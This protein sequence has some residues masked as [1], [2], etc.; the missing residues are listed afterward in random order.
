LAEAIGDAAA[1]ASGA[2]RLGD[3]ATDRRTAPPSTAEG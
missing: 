3:V 2:S 1:I